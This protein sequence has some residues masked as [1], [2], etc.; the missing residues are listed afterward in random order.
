M[1]LKDR[2]RELRESVGLTQR[3][4]AEN[5]HVSYDNYNKWENGYS[6]N[7]EKL[8]K[9]A[10]YYNTTTDYLL[11]RTAYKY[12]P[13]TQFQL[14]WENALLPRIIN[15]I[16]DFFV[17]YNKYRGRD[18]AIVLDRVFFNSIIGTVGAT[19]EGCY[20]L[21]EQ[22]ECAAQKNDLDDIGAAIN[23]FL[24]LVFPIQRGIGESAPDYFWGG[25][26]L[27]E[28]EALIHRGLEKRIP[29]YAECRKKA[30]LESEERFKG[31]I[32]EG[33]DHIDLDEQMKIWNG[34][35][36]AGE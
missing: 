24:T 20:K 6:P 25:A 14:A 27:F 5:I 36:E 18:N 10:D 34:A 13:D 21:I 26:N 9:I 33:F 15:L 19:L 3:Q 17:K 29:N 11:G 23:A 2:L 4:L 22:L 30:I 32:E 16:S 12:G 7:Y 35:E 8:S 31:Q 1:E 28:F